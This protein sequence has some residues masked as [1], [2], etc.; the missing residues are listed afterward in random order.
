M[1]DDKNTWI[2]DRTYNFTNMIKDWNVSELPYEELANFFNIYVA[3]FDCGKPVKTNQSIT[4][5]L[6]SILKSYLGITLDI[7]KTKKQ[8]EGERKYVFNYNMSFPDSLMEI[9]DKIKVEN[10]TNMKV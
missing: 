7:D 2:N 8:V 4:K 10:Q 9:F 6:S 1:T 3:T 5:R